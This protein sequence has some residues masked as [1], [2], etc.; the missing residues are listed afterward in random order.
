VAYASRRTRAHTSERAQRHTKPLRR[1][2][3]AFSARNE[4]LS[5]GT[6]IT[7]MNTSTY[8]NMLSTV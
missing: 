1:H 4:E 2:V 7:G 6:Y 8:N 3:R 5:T